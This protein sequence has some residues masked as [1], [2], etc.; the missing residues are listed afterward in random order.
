MCRV[1]LPLPRVRR[2]RWRV[3]SRQWAL[4]GKMDAGDLSD[5]RNVAVI[6]GFL[7]YLEAELAKMDKALENRVL[8][9]LEHGEFTPQQA[10]EAWYEKATYTK[11]LRRLTQVV[12][13][14][15]A[16]GSAYAS[17]LEKA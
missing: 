13:I 1:L 4:G 12:R 11:L 8:T 16:K 17:E 15:Q 2:V 9:A 10:L 6:Q 14:G 7:P 5:I 3:W